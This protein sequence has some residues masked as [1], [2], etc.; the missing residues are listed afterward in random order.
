AQARNLIDALPMKVK[1]PAQAGYFK[2]SLDKVAS[3][4]LTHS[5]FMEY[6]ER[7]VREV[8]EVAKVAEMADLPPSQGRKF[9]AQTALASYRTKGN[10]LLAANANLSSGMKRSASC[11]EQ[12]ILKP[13]LRRVRHDYFRT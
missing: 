5:E 4:T 1:D 12:K 7:F 3:G 8:V 2:Q 6:A 9:H 13:Y 11:L 10:V